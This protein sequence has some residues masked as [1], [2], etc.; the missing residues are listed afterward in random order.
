MLRVILILISIVLI[1]GTC[2]G[3]V[4]F[5]AGQTAYVVASP[6]SE[7]DK[8]VLGQLTTYLERVLRKKGRDGGEFEP[9]TFKYSGYLALP[10]W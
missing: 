8:R 5:P 1:A 4:L 10:C 7:L 6:R 9:C 3:S 2:F